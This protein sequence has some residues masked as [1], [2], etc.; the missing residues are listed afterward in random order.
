M[1]SAIDN[2]SKSVSH[3]EFLD[4]KMELNVSK[5]GA[6]VVLSGGQDSM[7]CLSMAKQ[8]LQGDK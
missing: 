3:A 4:F 2:I 6:V 8:N 1:L 7:T 5:Q